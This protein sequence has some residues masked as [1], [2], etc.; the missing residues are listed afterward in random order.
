MGFAISPVGFLTSPVENLLLGLTPENF[1]KF[2]IFPSESSSSHGAL[3]QGVNSNSVLH[4]TELHFDLLRMIKTKDFKEKLSNVLVKTNKFKFWLNFLL[5]SKM[6]CRKARLHWKFLPIY[7]LLMWLSYIRKIIPNLSCNNDINITS[8]I[9]Y[10][11][12]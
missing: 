10:L 6:F 12:S 5:K 9:N 11:I 8:W 1:W 4:L 3:R 7:K 2:A